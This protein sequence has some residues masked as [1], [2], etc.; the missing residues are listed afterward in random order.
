MNYSTTSSYAQFIIV[1]LIFVGVLAVT[2][3]VTKWTAGYTKKRG[4]GTN[5][6]LIESAPLATNKHIQIVRIGEKYIALAI[7]KD[8][9]S[10][11]TELEMD[12]L[13]INKANAG[14]SFRDIMSRIK[15]GDD[16]ENTVSADENE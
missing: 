15:T 7:T 6:E 16:S 12:Q 1:L 11:L 13:D 5:I 9:V 14:T 10:V 4:T 8:N 2:F 3:F